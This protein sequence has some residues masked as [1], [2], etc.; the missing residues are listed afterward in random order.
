V[1]T[2]ISCIEDVEREVKG[3]LKGVWIAQNPFSFKKLLFVR[4]DINDKICALYK[5]ARESRSDFSDPGAHMK[6][7]E[8]I[9]IVSEAIRDHQTRWTPASIKRDRDAYL[10]SSRHT[11]HIVR[12]WIGDMKRQ[13]GPVL[14]L[15]EMSD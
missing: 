5:F 10:E 11:E 8:D 15:A 12:M 7:C 4:T 6:F 2:T 13:L 9:E 1:T 3:L 14:Q